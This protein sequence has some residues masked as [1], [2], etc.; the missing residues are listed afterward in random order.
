MQRGGRFGRYRLVKRMAAGG[1]SDIYLAQ[2]FGEQGYERTA[3]VKMIRPDLVDDDESIQTL[4]DEARIASG[5]R[6][7]NIVE[8]YEVGETEGRPFLAMEFVFGRDLRQ[9]LERCSELGIAIPVPH[10]ITIFADVLDALGHAHTEAVF[11]GRPMSVVHRDVSP[12]NVLVGFDGAT[13]LLDFGLAKATAQISKTTRAGV[14]KGKYAYMSPEQVLFRGVDHRADIFSSGVVLWE[15][16][17]GERL[18]ARSNEYETVRA[19]VRCRVPW[20]RRPDE[21]FPWSVLW[22]CFWA[23]RKAPRWRFGSARSMRAALVREDARSPREARDELADWLSQLYRERLTV[24]EAAIA[25]VR[26]QPTRLRQVRESGFELVDEVSEPNLLRPSGTPPSLPAPSQTRPDRTMLERAS[27][28]VEN[29]T[30]FGSMFVAFVVFCAVLGTLVG[31]RLSERPGHGY[32][33]VFSNVDSVEVSIG[34]AKVGQTPVQRIAV[35]P[36]LHRVVGRRG[37]LVS[38]V[39]VTVEQ[40]ENRVVQL[41]FHVER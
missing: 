41:E 23:L 35:Q 2:V 22:A 20:P 28:I 10:L 18:F 19:V 15:A 6:H 39:E 33:Y 29:R 30:W 17:T 21:R 3:V 38:A 7:E 25:R 32:L 12:Q 34:E 14:L 1:M 13:K 16:L 24:R 4:M 37:D 40:G 36:G 11:D 8:L 31:S 26:H 5:L 9:V 27:G